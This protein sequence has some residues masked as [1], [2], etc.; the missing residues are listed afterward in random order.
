MR[1]QHRRYT[2]KRVESKQNKGSFDVQDLEDYKSA[3]KESYHRWS[4]EQIVSDLKETVC[5]VSESTFNEEEHANIPT[6][7]YELPDGAEVHIGSDRFKVPEILFNPALVS[8]FPDA[9]SIS[10]MGVLPLQSVT[11]LVMEAIAKVDVDM[12]KEL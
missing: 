7:T 10:N 5:R 3:T 11:S 8:T 6:V 9:N 2:F 12:R 1:F 4:V